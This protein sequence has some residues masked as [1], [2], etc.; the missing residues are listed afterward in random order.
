[1]DQLNQYAVDVTLDPATA[2]GWLE[3]S[4]DGKKVKHCHIA[5]EIYCIYVRYLEWDGLMIIL[6]KV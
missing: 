4:A 3:L 6:Q 5:F 1:M 2:S